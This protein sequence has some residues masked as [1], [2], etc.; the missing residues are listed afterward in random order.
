MCPV[1][2]CGF[3]SKKADSKYVVGSYLGPGF[4]TANPVGAEAFEKMDPGVTCSVNKIDV[5]GT[6]T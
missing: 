6:A 5:D 1:V 4:L 2:S 3:E